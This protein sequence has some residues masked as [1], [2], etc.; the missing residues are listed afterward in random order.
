MSL[1]STVNNILFFGMAFHIYMTNS[2]PV[3]YNIFIVETAHFCVLTYSR[4]QIFADKLYRNLKKNPM[5]KSYTDYFEGLVARFFNPDVGNVE[6]IKD[7]QVFAYTT[8]EKLKDLFYPAELMDFIIY[9]DKQKSGQVNKI[10]CYNK[11]YNFS[12]QKCK[13]KFVSLTVGFSENEQYNLK[14][15]TE[16]ENYFIVNNRLNKYLFCYL[17]RKQFGIIKDET[18]VCYTLEILDQDVNNISLAEKDEIVLELEKYT[19]RQM[20]SEVDVAYTE[21]RADAKEDAPPPIEEYIKVGD[22]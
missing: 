6:I 17:I 11:P 9:S 10:V 15:F 18:T 4:L 20:Y 1:Y 3:Q 13:F 8:V 12:Y 16:K 21:T 14:L 22:E 7:S 5:F 2:Y 19:I